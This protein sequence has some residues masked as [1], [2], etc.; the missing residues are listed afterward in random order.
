M[1]LAGCGEHVV[2]SLGQMLFEALEAQGAKRPVV[3]PDYVPQ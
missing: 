2:D 1:D 3:N